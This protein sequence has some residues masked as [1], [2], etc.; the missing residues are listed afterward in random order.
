MTVPAELGVLAA[1]LPRAWEDSK[2]LRPHEVSRTVTPFIA[3]MRKLSLGR[4]RNTL[5][6]THS[7]N[8]YSTAQSASRVQALNHTH[9]HCLTLI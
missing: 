2:C 8:W 5:P 3:Q 6:V 7:S 4:I 9:F 1:C